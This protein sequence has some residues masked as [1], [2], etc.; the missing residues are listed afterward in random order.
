VLAVDPQKS[1]TFEWITFVT[2]SLAGHSTP[3]VVPEA[4][5]NVRPIP[6]QVEI[7]FEA[8]G[9]SK[10]K[11]TLAHRGFGSGGK[12]DE[13]Y[14]YFDQAWAGVLASLAKAYA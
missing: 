12:W 6:T 9:D 3:P 8:L 5:R 1:I 13:A 4:V 10:T 11:I 2:K 14:A 7:H